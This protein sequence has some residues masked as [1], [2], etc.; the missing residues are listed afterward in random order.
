M[1][2]NILFLVNQEIFPNNGV[3]KKI[4]SQAY[5]LKNIADKFYFS[6][7]STKDNKLSRFIGNEVVATFAANKIGR[8]LALFFW[9]TRSIYDF[10]VNNN[11]NVVYMR[12]TH[13]SNPFIY[14]LVKKL[15]KL[16]VRMYIEVPTYPY[17]DEYQFSLK[18]DY[19][20]FIIDVLF[21]KKVFSFVDNVITFSNEDLIFERQT[22]K[23]SN[24]V[25]EEENSY[26]NPSFN[27]KRLDF[28]G[29]ANLA[30]WHGYDRFITS[31]S[32]YVKSENSIDVYFHLVGSGKELASLKK[33][34]EELEVAKYVYFYGELDGSD[35]DIVYSKAHVGVD[36]LGRHRSGN[37]VNNS[38]KSKE[39]VMRGLPLIKSH[40]DP[41]VDNTDYYFQIDS[42]DEPFD[43][44]DIVKWYINYAYYQKGNELRS[45]AIN[46][47]TWV[48]Q[49]DQL[50]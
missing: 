29:V 16:G 46:N 2:K 13:F 49:F 3:S 18:P 14:I 15:S 45:Y 27:L 34:A 43:L 21:R 5:A 11:I 24:A 42:S 32:K 23:L 39:Y 40:I 7:L 48:K 36:S 31:L 4:L 22:L 6:K 50:F 1:K 38:L 33:L 12:Y 28:I 19:L 9:D 26:A 35:L 25:S 41:S 47:Y 20:R 8:N 30:F 37:R 44:H 10:V 17:D